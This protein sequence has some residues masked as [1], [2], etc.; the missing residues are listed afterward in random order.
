MKTIWKYELEIKD[1]HI[2][3]IPSPA[4]P[5]G[6]QVQYGKPVLWCLVD[7]EKG[8]VKKRFR[9]AGTGHEILFTLEELNYIGTIQLLGGNLIY[10]LFEILS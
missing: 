9:M 3:E 2:L 10:H 8:M 1:E 5:L 4:I 7:P 6:F